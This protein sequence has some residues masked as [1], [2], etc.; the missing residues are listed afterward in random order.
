MISTSRPQK[1]TF[2]KAH[3]YKF[4]DCFGKDIT[5]SCQIPRFNKSAQLEAYQSKEK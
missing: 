2:L 3:V 4:F 1:Y 5:L